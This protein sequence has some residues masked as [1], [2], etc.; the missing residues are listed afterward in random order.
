MPRNNRGTAVIAIFE[1][2]QEIPS[3]FI[4][5]VTSFQASRHVQ[6][7]IPVLSTFIEAN[8]MQHALCD[9]ATNYATIALHGTRLCWWH[10]GGDLS[11]HAGV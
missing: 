10:G 3:V 8:Q 2:F 1:R 5:S 11:H 4:L 7:N 6:L 9:M